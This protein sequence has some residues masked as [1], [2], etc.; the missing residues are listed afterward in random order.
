MPVW[1][2][3]YFRIALDCDFPIIEAYHCST[4][5]IC[6]QI[7]TSLIKSIQERNTEIINFRFSGQDD[8]IYYFV[9]DHEF[10]FGLWVDSE[11][12]HLIV[13]MEICTGYYEIVKFKNNNV[14]PWERIKPVVDQILQNI[15]HNG[16][17]NY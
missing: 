6:N 12:E 15:E 5:T 10:S 2:Y 3:F 11:I 13:E 4:S 9:T 1:I 7:E 14:N 17:F 8:H 16:F